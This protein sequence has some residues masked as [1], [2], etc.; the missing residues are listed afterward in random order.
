[1]MTKPRDGLRY[2]VHLP[3]VKKVSGS[4]QRETEGGARQIEVVTRAIRFTP[5]LLP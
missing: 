2:V 1:M 3:S 5:T 4:Q